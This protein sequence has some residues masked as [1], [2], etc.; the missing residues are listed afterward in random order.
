MKLLAEVTVA[1]HNVKNTGATSK[2]PLKSLLLKEEL[3][4]VL[5]ESEQARLA[6]WLTPLGDAR[7]G[8]SLSPKEPSEVSLLAASNSNLALI[9]VGCNTEVGENSL[10]CEPFISSSSHYEIS[11][12]E[13]A[14]RCSIS[15]I[16]FPR[17]GYPRTRSPTNSSRRT[18][19]KRCIL[20]IKGMPSF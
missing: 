20:P 19:S 7:Y 2:G 14:C 3:L 9:N 11:F 13:V 5:L 10:G 12:S 16:E 4:N 1:L 17:Q 8:A 15:L 6:V 18:A